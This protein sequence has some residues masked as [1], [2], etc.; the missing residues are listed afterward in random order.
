MTEVITT[1]EAEPKV[2]TPEQQAAVDTFKDLADLAVVWTEAN[3]DSLFRRENI[4]GHTVESHDGVGVADVRRMLA[5]RNPEA[6]QQDIDVRAARLFNRIGIET[7]GAQ[8]PEDL[9]RLDNTSETARIKPFD[10]ITY[11]AVH[12][13]AH[14]DLG[15]ESDRR[16]LDGLIE[17]AASGYMKALG[18]APESPEATHATD[19]LY[20]A[21]RNRPKPSKQYPTLP[22]YF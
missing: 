4:N 2:R 6:P 22:E 9:D 5:A 7:R 14:L 1:N 15:D 17:K 11:A 16:E 20:E 18:Y 13:G 21:V 8:L 3:A 10:V 19:R 12:L